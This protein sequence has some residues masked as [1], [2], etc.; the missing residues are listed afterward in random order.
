MKKA[1]YAVLILSVLL[2]ALITTLFLASS[3]LDYNAPVNS[4]NI[5]VEGW[6]QAYELEQIKEKYQ[7]INELIVVGNE[8]RQSKNTTDRLLDYFQKQVSK[9]K[10][11]KGMWLYANSTLIFSPELLSFKEAGDTLQIVVRARGTKMNGRFAHFNLI[12]NGEFC[13]ESFTAG[14]TTDYVFYADAGN[15]GVETVG[16]RFDNDCRLRKEDRNLFILSIKVNGR[17]IFANKNTSLITTTETRFTTGFTSKAEATLNYLKAL[18]VKAKSYRTVSFIL[19]RENQTL[20]AANSFRE[21]VTTT[22]FKSFNIVSAGTHSRRSLVTYEKVLGCDYNIGV[23]NL[24]SARY[25]KRNWW[26]SP[27]GWF[28]LIDESVSYFINL[29]I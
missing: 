25:N 28:G 19:T 12:V 5:V 9:E 2:I 29:F 14:E 4:D 26:K 17:Q 3:Y 22:G 21:W 6:L 11:G 15:A 16:V 18:N 7:N 1:R 27:G 13:D 8:F 24:E 23:I 20:A 10:P